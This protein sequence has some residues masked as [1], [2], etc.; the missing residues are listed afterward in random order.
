MKYSKERWHGE[1][2]K[3]SPYLEIT[4]SFDEYSKW[5]STIL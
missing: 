3:E 2:Y 5:I 1:G 4:A